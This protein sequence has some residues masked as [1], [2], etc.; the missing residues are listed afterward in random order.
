MQ[1]VP[2]GI[3]RKKPRY[4]TAGGG[5]RQSS[6]DEG[7]KKPA[8]VRVWYALSGTRASTT[9]TGRPPWQRNS[10]GL[11]RRIPTTT[12]IRGPSLLLRFAIACYGRPEV[13][14]VIQWHRG[15][16]ALPKRLSA[17]GYGEGRTHPISAQGPRIR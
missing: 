1:T 11:I 5:S 6:A 16:S 13:A 2:A 9:V 4:A 3:A 8:W 12:F 15:K 17:P 10:R 14:G 7:S